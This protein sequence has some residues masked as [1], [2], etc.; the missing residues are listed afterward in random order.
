MQPPAVCE[1]A[2]DLILQ[3]PGAAVATAWGLCVILDQR[4]RAERSLA[5]DFDLR[6]FH[7][8]LIGEGP[9]PSDF[10]VAR[11]SDWLEDGP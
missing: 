2:V 9:L 6:G 3:E 7:A 11:V 8:L 1:K 5:L 10:I 4:K